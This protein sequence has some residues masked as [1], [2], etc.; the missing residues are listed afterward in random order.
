MS[1]T[2]AEVVL[3]DIRQSLKKFKK[4]AA[5][6]PENY[7]HLYA[8]LK[9]E[10]YRLH[11]NDN[12]AELYY[13]RAIRLASMNGFVQDT[14]LAYERAANYYLAKQQKKTA[15]HYILNG[16][17]NIEAWGAETVARRWARDYQVHRK[18]EN[19]S[20]E[21]LTFD[22]MTVLRRLNLLQQP[23]VWKNYCIKY[24]FP[25]KARGANS[26]YFIHKQQ[27]ELLVLAKAEAAENLYDV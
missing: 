1:G 5:Y 19:Q 3:T 20:R 10:N 14:A 7:E 9:A 11:N 23:S 4:W 6:S 17:Q 25:V 22:M 27:Q 24:C 8:L 15:R 18:L 16:I 2:R 21:S 13:D 26:G 12:K